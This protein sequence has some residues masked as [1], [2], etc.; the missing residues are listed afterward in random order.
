[1]NCV[2][3]EFRMGTPSLP[4]PRYR[5]ERSDQRRR[6]SVQSA[7]PMQSPHPGGKAGSQPGSR[8]QVWAVLGAIGLLLGGGGATV[9]ISWLSLQ[10]IIQPQAMQWVSRWVP[11][12]QT[13]QTAAAPTKTLAEI[14]TELQQQG[15]QPGDRLLLGHY[16]SVLDGKTVTP[17]WLMPIVQTTASCVTGCDRL[18]ELRV[19]QQAPKRSKTLAA[20]ADY[21]LVAQLPLAGLEESFAIAPLVDAASQNQGSSRLLPLTHL[22]RF[23]GTHLE[24]FWFNVSGSR[25]RGDEAIA[26]GQIVYYHPAAQHL[27]VKL[28]WTS[29]AAETPVWQQ[30]TGDNSPELLVNQ[31]I[32]M[33]PQFEIYQVKAQRFI[34]SPVQLELISLSLPEWD[35]S[36]YQ[37]ALLLARSRL[38]STSLDWMQALQARSPHRWTASMQ[39]QMDVIQWHAQATRTQAESSW[40]SPGQQILANL[41]DGRWERAIT[42]FESSVEASQETV[43]LL[44]ADQGRLEN[45]VKAALRVA[46][47]KLEIQAW[48]ALLIAAQQSPHQAIAWLQK[49][50]K[51]QPAD[52]TQIRALLQRLD[53]NFQ[54][55]QRDT[56]PSI[57]PL[58]PTSPVRQPASTLPQ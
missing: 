38:W 9:G 25:T 46:P 28:S 37:S 41:L 16:R 52:I 45:R 53:P 42:V 7:R 19:Y 50:P 33:E 21:Y 20:E 58:P 31:T 29:P 8:H 35:E 12:W 56:A 17:E 6:S 32:G 22:H 44:K 5:S 47:G 49:Q 15:L 18:V 48:G 11:G 27:S 34:A 2:T 57:N 13:G 4:P 24:G 30:I 54:P 26:Y 14:R 51:T 1:M 55:A 3:D 40:A 43:G 23:E 36:H 39:A 10:L